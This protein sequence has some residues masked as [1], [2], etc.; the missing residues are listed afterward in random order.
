MEECCEGVSYKDVSDLID[1][2]LNPPQVT[3][4]ENTQNISFF[5]Q[6][7]LNTDFEEKLPPSTQPLV[8]TTCNEEETIKDAKNEAAVSMSKINFMQSTECGGKLF[9]LN[10]NAYHYYH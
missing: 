7:T 3:Q 10:F 4:K 8:F 9:H 1:L 5:S 6:E 2:I